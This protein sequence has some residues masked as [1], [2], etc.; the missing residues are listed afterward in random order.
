MLLVFAWARFRP[1]HTFSEH[2]CV[3]GRCCAPTPGYDLPCS[4]FMDIQEIWEANVLI[5]PPRLVH[6][7]SLPVTTSPLAGFVMTLSPLPVVVIA[8]AS[9]KSWKLRSI[10]TETAS[11][12]RNGSW[13]CVPLGF[14]VTLTHALHH[15][16]CCGQLV[17]E[18]MQW[19]ANLRVSV[20][21]AS[22]S[23]GSFAHNLWNPLLELV[24]RAD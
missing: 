6:L 20:S 23:G 5:L 19:K 17:P 9:V 16:W 13:C 10:R 1:A 4:T 18:V 12:L 3:S 15:L 21:T 8:T 22:S 11:L 24:S 2:L 14:C 7:A